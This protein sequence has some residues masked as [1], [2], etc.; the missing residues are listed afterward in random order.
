MLDKKEL[1]LYAYR[2]AHVVVNTVVRRV[3]PTTFYYGIRSLQTR[4][5][6]LVLCAMLPTTKFID[7]RNTLL[8][9]KVG[10]SSLGSSL[11]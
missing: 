9:Y 6:V 11:K 2:F 7:C 3:P 8:F 5:T 10:M 1:M 4:L